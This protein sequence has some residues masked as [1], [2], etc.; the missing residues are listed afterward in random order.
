MTA[1]A[2]TQH[3]VGG[4]LLDRPLKIRRLGHFGL[5]LQRLPQSLQFYTGLV[6]CRVSDTLDFRTVSKN[7]EIFDGIEDPRVYF[8][9]FHGDH[10]AFVLGSKQASD[11][12]RGTVGHDSTGQMSW[13]VGGL[14]EV[15]NTIPWLEERG[16]KLRNVGR[17]M[18]GSNWHV[19]FTDPDGR[20]VELF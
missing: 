12:R 16:L 11:A 17:D 15:G 19:Y 1:T 14:S 3:D 8:M 20:T 5:H 9:R 13:Q 10:H 4:V 2:P 18:P 6:G 7:P